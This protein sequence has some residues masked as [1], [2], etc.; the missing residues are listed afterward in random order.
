MKEMLHNWVEN[1][2]DADVMDIMLE[3]LLFFLMTTVVL[4][5]VGMIWATLGSTIGMVMAIVFI[6]IPAIIIL[7]HFS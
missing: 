1:I 5:M 6:G 3:T 4:I 7:I 2:R